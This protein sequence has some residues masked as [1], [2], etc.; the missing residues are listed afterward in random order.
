VIYHALNVQAWTGMRPMQWDLL[1]PDKD[2]DAEAR[3]V[4]VHSVKGDR[5]VVKELEAY[6]V[7]ALQDAIASNAVR[8]YDRRNARRQWYAE[9][10]ALNIP[11]PWPHPYQLKHSYLTEAMIGTG[12]PEAVREQS[13]LR[14]QESLGRYTEAGK[15]AVRRRVA[16]A[17][18]ARM[19][20]ILA[21]PPPSTKGKRGKRGSLVVFEKPSVPS[22]A[23]ADYKARG[24]P[25]RMLFGK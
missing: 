19:E 10:K 11:K 1:Q 13:G 25:K 14:R 5:G 7:Q 2:F 16:D 15:Q 18:G 3:T 21:P 12:D 8:P 4:K 23:P 20:A 24:G 22:L 9:F 17:F 6:G